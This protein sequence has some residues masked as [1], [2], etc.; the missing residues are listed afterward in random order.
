[1]TVNTITLPAAHSS[2]VRSCATSASGG[3]SFMGLSGELASIILPT[4]N[5]AY[6]L[7]ATLDSVLRQSYRAFEIVIIDDGSSDGTADL[8]KTRYGEDPRIRYHYQNN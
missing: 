2:G 1:M 3:E 5:R 7:P 8:I 6:C 4:Y